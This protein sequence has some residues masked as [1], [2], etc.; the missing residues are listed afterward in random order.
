LDLTIDPYGWC[1]RAGPTRRHV[2]PIPKEN[3]VSNKPVSK[4]STVNDSWL[5][6]CIVRGWT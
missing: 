5:A 1:R 6:V 4:A 3:P 2:E